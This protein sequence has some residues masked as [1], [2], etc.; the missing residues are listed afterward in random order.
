MPGARFL[1]FRFFT[2]AYSAG[3]GQ[4]ESMRNF[5]DLSEREMLALAIALEEED[6]RVYDDYADGLR[7][8]F[9]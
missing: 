7:E 5:D 6:E 2:P 1:A 4:T 8:D 3:M 9:A